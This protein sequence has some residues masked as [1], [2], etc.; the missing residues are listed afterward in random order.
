[1]GTSG[2]QPADKPH[3]T[4]AEIEAD[5]AQTRESLAHTLD[6]LK[7]ELDPRVQAGRLADE[8]KAK[9]SEVTEQAKAAA[10]AATEE[11][12]H[13]AV[14]VGNG[15]PRALAIAGAAVA[16]LVGVVVVAV[17]RRHR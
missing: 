16:A 3:R 1:M 8:A 7:V 2:Q 17:A 11:A 6:A 15:A 4:A 13:F 9:A 14:D 10:H 12:K 5:I